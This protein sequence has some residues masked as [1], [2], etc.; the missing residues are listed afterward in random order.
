MAWFI[1]ITTNHRL[2]KDSPWGKSAAKLHE[3]QVFK[4]Y[5]RSEARSVHQKVSLLLFSAITLKGCE[6][7][8]CCLSLSSHQPPHNNSESS[9][10]FTSLR[11]A[12]LWRH[13]PGWNKTTISTSITSQWH[14]IS[15]FYQKRLWI[16]V[17]CI[18]FQDVRLKPDISSTCRH[19]Q[20]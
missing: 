8:S 19:F 1:T 7:L 20:F 17:Y 13:Y 3:I 5:N 14:S 18:E 11:R 15:T 9:D 6:I 10:R 16:T 2:L 12:A 4:G